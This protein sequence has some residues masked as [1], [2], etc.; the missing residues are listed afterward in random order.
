[1]CVCVTATMSQWKSSNPT[2][3]RILKE[4]E[5]MRKNPSDLFRAWPL[6][7][8][9]FEWHFTLR[10]PL[11]TPYARGLY[12]GRLQLP[13]D[14]P[15]KPPDLFFMT[16]SGRFE[17][18]TK[19]CLSITSYHPET[20]QPVSISQVLEAV[21]VHFCEEGNGSIGAVNASAERREQLALESWNWRC[22]SCNLCNSE[23]L[24]PRS[25][26]D[27][28]PGVSS[29][30]AGPVASVNSPPPPP[31][32]S[33][34]QSLSADRW[35]HSPQS[36]GLR[37]GTT[38]GVGG[39]STSHVRE[40]DFPGGEGGKERREHEDEDADRTPAMGPLRSPFAHSS[41]SASWRRGGGL[42]EEGGCTPGAHGNGSRSLTENQSL[43]E[44]T[45]TL[46]RMSHHARFSRVLPA[47][48]K[49]LFPSPLDGAIWF[50]MTLLA[51]VVVFKFSLAMWI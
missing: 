51:V 40:V 32:P 13:T 9:I 31:P 16:P 2:V 5:E 43:A 25:V 46:A 50:A 30:A 37:S 45:S 24:P 38:L 23:C 11:D 47:T 6:E 21:I 12:H 29:P 3:K 48:F 33:L 39:G 34:P 4:V 42:C 14:W 49:S 15:F 28:Q 10:G 19:I 35:E 41:S 7:G 17:L 8:D 27:L 22:K 44:H 36:P 18:D 20:Y 1:M 26:E